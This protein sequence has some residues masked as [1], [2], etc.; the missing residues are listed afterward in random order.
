MWQILPAKSCTEVEPGGKITEFRSSSSLEQFQ[1]AQRVLVPTLQGW[2][3][4]PARVWCPQQN[5]GERLHEQDLPG[6]K[7]PFAV[8]VGFRR[9]VLTDSLQLPK[10]TNQQKGK[11]FLSLQMQEVEFSVQITV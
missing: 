1:S 6:E 10:A 9:G 3:L 8:N 4:L 2:E 5:F 7:T 11:N